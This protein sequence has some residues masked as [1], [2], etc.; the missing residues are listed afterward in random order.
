M[1]TSRSST[2]VGAPART[3]AHDLR[4]RDDASLA[5]LFL[6]RPDLARPTPSDMTQVAS[7]AT[8]RYSV[9]SALDGL[10][11]LGL[12]CVDA[13]VVLDGSASTVD[14]AA[15]L[16]VEH[17][18]ARRALTVLRGL[19]L[20]WGPD[21]D[22]RLVRA[23]HDV[24]GPHPAGLGPSAATLGRRVPEPVDVR[25]LAA[26][27]SPPARRLLERLTWGPPAAHFADD[28]AEARA[29]V[30][31]LVS[32]GLL[33]EVEARQV[34]LPREIGLA[35]RDGVLCA[36]RP[37]TAPDIAT[38]TAPSVDRVAV[39]A[40][41]EA[42]RHVDALLTSWSEAGPTVLRGGG[43]GVRE[44]R[45]LSV[46]LGVEED[47]AGFLVELAAAAGLLSRRSDHRD[48]DAWTPTVAYDV[49]TTRPVAAR[50]SDLVAAWLDTERVTAMVGR[51][52]DKGRLVNPLAPGLHRRTAPEA[53]RLTL[54]TLADLTPSAPVSP[55]EVVARVRWLRPRLGAHRDLVVDRTLTEASWLGVTG[56]GALTNAGTALLREGPVAA[57]AALEP[58]VPEPVDRLLLQ[59]DLTAV[60]PGPLTRQLATTMELMADVESQGGATVYRFSNASV[61]RTLDAGWPVGQVHDFLRT[62]SATAVPQ[63][64]TFLVDDT[65]RRH[66]R[67]RL[68][69]ATLYLRSDDP[70]ELDA[71]VA[72]PALAGLHLRRIAPT[73][74]L[75]DTDE[76]LV[77]RD[78]RASGHAPLAEALDG[79][80]H[81]PER[82]TLRAATPRGQH[83]SLA[84]T[85]SAGLSGD[86]ALM[87]VEAVRAGDAVAARRPTAA[88]TTTRA[89]SLDAL[90]ALR[91]AAQESGSVWMSYLD[92]NGTLSERVVDPL[93]VDAGWLTAHDH[94]SNSSRRFAV[95]RIRRVAPVRAE[96][97]GEANSAR[98][99]GKP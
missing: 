58:A 70:T 84:G 24:T 93:R 89:G 63:P 80:V 31:E 48:E 92:Q 30:A 14:V 85:A 75:T 81:L 20:A 42:V 38:T 97:L 51:R 50:W 9:T 96:I 74:A 55:Q 40:A 39:G 67:L 44:V 83:A 41:L 2:V 90:A 64:L 13:L 99:K 36:E 46:T 59:A 95:H 17:E 53:R 28:R 23:V 61:R 32:E 11:T 1:G 62:H 3:L 49:W 27:L 88:A 47:R 22:V 12:V 79:S 29:T 66:G 18:V 5:E 25:A 71:L 8:S 19:A 68:G 87:L 56:M 33:V 60:A 7:R 77:I 57:A 65:A 52:D 94:R 91:E 76:E 37:D 82:R 43:V 73:V 6:A 26:A 54:S 98:N 15:L 10:D 72:D 86:E 4:A 69:A 45:A 16:G 35:L 78:L 21:D 34:V